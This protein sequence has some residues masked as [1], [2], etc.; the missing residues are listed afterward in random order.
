[1][2]KIVCIT[3]DVHHPLSSSWW[4]KN[5]VNFCREYVHI[6]KSEKIKAT[7]FVTGKCIKDNK[8]FFSKINENIELGG[9]TYWCFKIFPFASVIF[10][11]IINSPYGPPSLQEK[12]IIKTIRIFKE[13]GKKINVWRTHQYAGDYETYAILNK[14]GFIAVSEKRGTFKIEREIGNLYQVYITMPKDEIISPNNEEKNEEWRN[15]VLRM[16]KEEIRK[17]SNIVFNLHP[18]RM[19]MLDNF[20]TFK[21]II[22]MLKKGGY[23]FLTITEVVKELKKHENV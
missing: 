6:I 14:L 1:M 19:K 23:K 9:H 2:N 3:G 15:R 18:K 8:N 21:K 11:L 10:K 13:I 16:L 5:E 12:D 7:I 22:K 17:K 20:N 4:D